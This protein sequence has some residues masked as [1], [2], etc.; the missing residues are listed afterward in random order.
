MHHPVAVVAEGF[1][2]AQAALVEQA[3]PG[4]DLVEGLVVVV[5]RKFHTTPIPQEAQEVRPA[6]PEAMRPILILGTWVVAVV[7]VDGV[8]QVVQAA[9]APAALPVL[10]VQV[11]RQSHSTDLQPQEVAQAQHMEQ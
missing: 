10:Q 7:A 1:Y 11:V 8:H 5:E 9:M 4:M 2:L 6:T 3:L